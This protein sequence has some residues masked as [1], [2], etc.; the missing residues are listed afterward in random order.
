[1]VE[2]HALFPNKQQKT[3]RNK[4]HGFFLSS[5]HPTHLLQSYY[6]FM[7]TSQI[8]ARNGGNFLFFSF[9]EK[10]S[11]ELL[12][13]SVLSS[14]NTDNNFAKIIPSL[15]FLLLSTYARNASRYISWIFSTFQPSINDGRSV[16][17]HNNNNHKSHMHVTNRKI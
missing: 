2:L 17:S 12:L 3:R 13:P 15:G 5:I 6:V 10:H 4:Q 7:S 14:V 8:S 11:S 9:K 16:K 1:M